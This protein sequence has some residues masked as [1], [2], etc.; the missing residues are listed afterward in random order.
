M[1]LKNARRMFETLGEK[2]QDFVTV[3][4][5]ALVEETLLRSGSMAAG[6]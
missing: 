3:E 5:T 2:D 1:L 4:D 6:S